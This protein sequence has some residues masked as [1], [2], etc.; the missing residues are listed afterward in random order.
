MAVSLKTYQYSGNTLQVNKTL[1]TA[2]SYSGDQVDN[3]EDLLNPSFI[4]NSSSVPQVNYAYCST[5]NRYYY[6]D[7]ITWVGG[8]AYQLDCHVDVLKTYASK[9]TALTAMVRFSNQGDAVE[10]EPRMNYRDVP[11]VTYTPSTNNYPAFLS[12]YTGDTN[13]YT[14][15]PLIML[16][17]HQLPEKTGGG[18]NHDADTTIQAAFMTQATF[19]AFIDRYLTQNN[20]A[21]GATDAESARVE[22]GS[23]IIDV[24]NVYYMSV[25]RLIAS[26]IAAHSDLVIRTPKYPGGLT[27]NLSGAG[28]GNIYVIQKLSDVSLLGYA[29]C[30]AFTIPAATWWWLN[31]TYIT[32]VPYIRTITSVPAKYGINTTETVYFAIAVDPYAAE[33]VITPVN[34]L[35]SGD[36]YRDATMRIPISTTNSFPVDTAVDNM[37]TRN[38]SMNING[39]IQTVNTLQSY[40]NGDG[41]M[42]VA[43]WAKGAIDMYGQYVSGNAA[44]AAHYKSVGAYNGATEWTPADSK[45]LWQISICKYPDT[46]P[47]AFAAEYG[48]P[49]NQVRLLSTI[50]GYA[51]VT[52]VIT[53]G[54]DT[55]TKTEV[56]EIVS[57]LKT[58]VIF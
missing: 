11:L 21:W 26:G 1:G 38:I 5:Y 49:D 7:R 46:D 28:V 54:F 32:K 40:N 25:K 53:T 16:R 39:L 14:T 42:S 18:I 8:T 52:E 30:P 57:L 20:T 13:D 50:S 35:L 2:T 27:V 56:D 3:Y 19:N 47:A 41:K 33:Y 36:W 24:T 31:A 29:A 6:I 12:D 45:K 55:A 9:I 58:G 43:D 4:I 48:Y 23:K 51:V 17:F 22:F 10:F 44:E 37:L 34:D 15:E